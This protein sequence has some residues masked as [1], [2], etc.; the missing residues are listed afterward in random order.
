VPE[1]PSDRYTQ[2]ISAIDKANAEDPNTV[3]IDGEKRPA[4]LVYSE[5][6]T[7]ALDMFQPHAPEALRLAARAQHI[8]RWKSPRSSYPMDRV[9]YLRWRTELKNMHADRTAEILAGSGYDDDTIARV[10][11]LIRK[12][13][14]KTDPDSQALEDVICLV[15]LRYYLDAFAVKHDEAKIIDILR[16]TW[17]KMSP[18]GQQAA[19]ALPLPEDVK[20]LVGRALAA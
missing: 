19:L 9:G 4:E 1:V 13:R 3:D 5:R 12:E 8:Q 18:E 14:P 20:A 16:K 10:K 7:A 11:S 15:F 2:A 17:V 6:M